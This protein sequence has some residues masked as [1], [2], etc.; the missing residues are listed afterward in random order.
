MPSLPKS[1]SA[2]RSAVGVREIIINVAA[3]PVAGGE[4]ALSSPE[5]DVAREADEDAGADA[6]RES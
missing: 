1:L 5:M 6:A 3:R 2:V 4:A